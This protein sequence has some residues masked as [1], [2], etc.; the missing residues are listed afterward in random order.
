MAEGPF[1]FEG[2]HY[3]ITDYDGR[4]LP[5]QRP[6][7][8]V[9]IGG[10]GKRVL[11]IAAREADIVGI[12]GTMTAGVVGPDAIATMTAQA[13]EEKVAIVRAAAGDRLADIEMN[14]RAFFVQ[15][16]DDADAAVDQ[17]A[18]WISVEPSMIR[19][20]PFALIGPP[21][22]IVEDLLARRERWGF[23]YVIVGAGEIDQFAP[24]VAEL[25]GT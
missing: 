20:S 9:L 8:P 25:A 11:S 7:P 13:V 19:E 22:K 2:T 21:A 1:S 10:G 24:V 14:I 3:R 5:I 6:H 15:V 16:T 23:S 4:P 17:V 12:N 18:S